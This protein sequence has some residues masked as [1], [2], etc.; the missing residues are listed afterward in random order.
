MFLCAT[1]PELKKFQILDSTPMQVSRD[2]VAELGDR[3]SEKLV[4]LQ[5]RQTGICQKRREL[6]S[7][8][9]DEL[10]RQ[11]VLLVS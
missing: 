7:Q 1:E 9:F 6:Y 4:Q 11:V 8:T 5:A 3:L 2:Q 10:I